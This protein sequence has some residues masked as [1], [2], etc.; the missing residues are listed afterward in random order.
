MNLKA[1]DSIKYAGFNLLSLANNHILD[2]GATGI[3]ET[4]SI[5]DKAG[6][7]YA[8]A[9]NNLDDARRPAIIEINKVT[10]GFLAYS[11]RGPHIA[12]HNS[13][14]AA[15]IDESVIISDIADLRRSV[16]II[17]I[18]LHFGM[19]YTDYP[20][21]RQQRLCHLI[22][23]SGASLILGHHPHVL[24]G[25]ETYKGCIIAYSLGEFIFDATAGNVYA[26]VAREKRKESIILSIF[27]ESG[28]VNN[29]E[30]IPVK[31][32]HKI[33]PIIVRN[34][35]MSSI[36]K[37]VELLSKPLEEN[38]LKDSMVFNKAGSE[39]IPYQIQVYLYHLKRL[40]FVFIF[41]QLLRIRARHLKLVFGFIKSKLKK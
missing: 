40:H 6:I 2:W 18:S 28:G 26:N 32:N 38:S 5:L 41:H 4:C 15:P 13:P 37:R 17:I 31:I 8:G 25:I 24:Q 16:D 1:I 27:F 34:E 19:I 12:T 11:M 7:T 3:Q 9:G 35:E 22:I 23:D 36:L 14:G 33:Q 20:N 10:V 30:I 21:L 29:H 39:L